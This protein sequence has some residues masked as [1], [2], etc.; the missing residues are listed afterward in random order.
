MEYSKEVWEAKMGCTCYFVLC[1]SE[2]GKSTIAT[3]H[4][5]LDKSQEANAH[6][7]AAAPILYKQLANLGHRFRVVAELAGLSESKID[8]EL[9]GANQA[10]AK[11]KGGQNVTYHI[12]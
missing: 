1:S 4:N 3:V 10:L 9:K 5:Q 11:A 12:R 8:T 2:Y 6:L 7:I